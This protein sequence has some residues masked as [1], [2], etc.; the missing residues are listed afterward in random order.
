MGLCRGGIG[1]DHN[2]HQPRDV[3]ERLRLGM[4]LTVMSGS[5]NLNIESVVSVIP[6]LKDGLGHVSFCVDDKL[7]EDLDSEGHIDHQVR[8]AISLGVRPMAAYKMAT[9]N[10]AAYYLSS[11]SSYWK[12]HSWQ[13]GRSI[14]S[15]QSRRCKVSKCFNSHTH[16]LG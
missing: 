13:A 7:A 16:N 15:R 14:D 2:A 12:H 6:L 5:M 3:V 11:G 8:R 4:M 9:L 1:D 10:A